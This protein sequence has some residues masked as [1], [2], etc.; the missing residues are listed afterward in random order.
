M[1]RSLK[2]SRLLSTDL[3]SASDLAIYRQMSYS[4]SRAVFAF[5]TCIE[6]IPGL[7][8]WY[9]PVGTNRRRFRVC[10][11]ENSLTW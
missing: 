3:I 6:K 1:I 4:G 11:K 8:G 7:G 2:P 10:R 5:Q 9:T